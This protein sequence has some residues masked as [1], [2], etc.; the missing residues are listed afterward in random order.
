M[1]ATVARLIE[2][3][4]QAQYY[5]PRGN[6]LWNEIEAVKARRDEQDARLFPQQAVPNQNPFKDR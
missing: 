5:V 1:D 2:L 4:T 3:L 6:G